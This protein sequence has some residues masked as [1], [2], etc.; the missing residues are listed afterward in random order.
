MSRRELLLDLLK[1]ECY[2]LLLREVN[3][4]TINII[5]KY[6]Q[7][8]RSDIA[9]LKFFLEGYDGIGT[10]TTVDRYKAIVEVTIM[11]DF[12]A[13]A[14]LILEALKDEIEFEEVG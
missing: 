1:Y 13:D 6:I 14:G 2:M 4:M 8:D 9:S 10:M 12:A 3:A 11:P 5:K 7:L